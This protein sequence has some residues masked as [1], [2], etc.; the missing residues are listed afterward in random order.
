VER[1]IA[2]AIGGNDEWSDDGTTSVTIDCDACALR[3]TSAC[4]GCLVSF[5]LDRDP[6][7]AVIFDAAEARAVRLLERGGLLPASR[8]EASAS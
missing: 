5:V 6:G 7:D 8:F 1:D 2:I 4:R 3:D